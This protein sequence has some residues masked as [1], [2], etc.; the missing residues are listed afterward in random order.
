MVKQLNLAHNR[1]KSD[2]FTLFTYFP[3][4]EVLDLS[5]NLVTDVPHDI[6]RVLGNISEL[7][8]S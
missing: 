1:L 5:S 8:L 7:N 2:V 4:L 3:A 6:A